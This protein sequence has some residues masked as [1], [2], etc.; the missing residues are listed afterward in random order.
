ME[1]LRRDMSGHI[2]EGIPDGFSLGSE[3]IAVLSQFIDVFSCH[4]VSN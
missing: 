2:T 4:D 3:L 1:L